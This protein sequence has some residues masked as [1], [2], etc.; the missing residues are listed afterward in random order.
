MSHEN[1]NTVNLHPNHYS[2][3]I[4]AGKISKSLTNYL[5]K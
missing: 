2:N 4:I 1:M 5:L 3:T